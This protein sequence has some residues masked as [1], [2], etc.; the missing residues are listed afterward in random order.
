MKLGCPFSLRLSGLRAP[1]PCRSVSG[2]G[3]QK[4]R[5]PAVDEPDFTILMMDVTCEGDS[6]EPRLDIC[7]EDDLVFDTSDRLRDRE[8]HLPARLVAERFDE[9]AV[10]GFWSDGPGD[11]QG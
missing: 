9:D 1:A 11:G 8:G 6:L 7:R 5:R 10:V 2:K 3:D 4:A